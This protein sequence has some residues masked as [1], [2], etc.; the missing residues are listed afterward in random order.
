MSRL[1]RAVHGVA[2]SYILL[3]ATA[4]YSLASVPVALHYLDARRFGLWVVMGT[5]TG[6][7]GLIDAGMT[8]AA[9]RLLVDYKDHRNDGKYG[10]FIKTGWLV[11]CL[12]GALIFVI[13]L[14]L[15]GTFA[16]LLA[17][18]QVLRP[19]FIRLVDWQCG[20]VAFSFATR[21]LYLILNGHQRMDLTNYI[22]VA[23]LALNFVIQWVLF[24]FNFGVLSLAFGAIAAAVF[25]TIC[26]AAA[27]A[28]LKLLPQ[29]D[30]WGRISRAYFVE[31]ANFGKDLF[32]VSV[33]TQLIMASQAIIITRM[34]GLEA[35]AVWGIGLRMFNLVNQ[36]IWRVSDMSASAF[37]EMMARGEISR[38]RDRYRSVA[39]LTFSLAGW[40]AVSFALC[41]SLFVSLWTHG[42]IHW[43]AHNDGLLAIWMILTA[44]VHCHNS[45]VLLTKKVGFMRYIYFVEGSVYVWFA[46]WV[47]RRGGFPAIIGCSI[48]CCLLFSCAYGIWRVSRFFEIPVAEV[49]FGWLYPMSKMM[50]F[51]LPAAGLV[52]WCLLGASDL[53][54]LMVHA[55]VAA[56]AGAYLFLRFGIPGAFQSELLQRIPVRVAPFLKRVFFQTAN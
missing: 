2:S 35:A 36:L 21:M 50:C 10:G 39:I 1:R 41:N 29:P 5:L 51:Y 6:Y 15:A 34:L 8:G 37:S 55:T 18:D 45:F 49:A 9:A 20:A 30:K 19:E 28:R 13:G 54:R 46:F 11:F 4:F 16:R 44:A 23:G 24:H 26:Q 3:A 14:A 31:I 27:C 53:T 7:L 48:V 22:G 33:G 47:A 42:K 38:L 43:P 52:W 25:T 12:Q 40:A 56:S 32:L 17:I